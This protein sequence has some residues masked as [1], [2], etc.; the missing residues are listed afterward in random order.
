MVQ[1]DGGSWQQVKSWTVQRRTADFM[2]LQR[3]LKRCNV[4]LHQHITRR[5]AVED[6]TEVLDAFL[7]ACA[8][9]LV[10]PGAPVGQTCSCRRLHCSALMSPAALHDTSKWQRA[11]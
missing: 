11:H 7:Q 9:V 1:K 4:V 3:L 2:Y 6:Q 5:T 8:L 10:S